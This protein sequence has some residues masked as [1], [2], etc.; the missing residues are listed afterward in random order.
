MVNTHTIPDFLTGNEVTEALLLWISEIF[1]DFSEV[2]AQYRQAVQDLQKALGTEQLSSVMDAVAMQ[3][4]SNFL[5]SV[6][7]GLKA[8]LDNFTDPVGRYFLDVDSE[9]YLREYTAHYL[10]KYVKAQN[11]LDYFYISLTSEQK[12][13][14][15][16][17]IAYCSY[18][19]TVVPKLGHYYG[20]ILGNRLLPLIVPGYHEDPM[21]NIRYR[22]LLKDYWGKRVKLPAE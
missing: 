19:E 3:T 18:L 22:M 15:D 7:L 16:S 1:E 4:S 12:E 11:V 10:P 21:L 8:N 14:Y 13:M 6:A 2:Q 20:Y 17:I 5:F 9:V